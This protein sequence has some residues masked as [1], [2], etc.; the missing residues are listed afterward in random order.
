MNEEFKTDVVAIGVSEDGYIIFEFDNP[1]R[2][3][4]FDPESA[5]LMAS[6]VA[7]LCLMISMD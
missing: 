5:L 7:E 3:V 1:K 4:L 2:Q 6:K